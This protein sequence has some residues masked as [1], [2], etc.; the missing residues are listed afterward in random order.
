MLNVKIIS[1]VALNSST[2]TLIDL[3]TLAVETIMIQCRDAIDVL[4][5][6]SDSPS[7][8]YW[9]MKSGT[10]VFVG[11]KGRQVTAGQFVLYAK[12][13]SSTPSLEIFIVQ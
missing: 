1:A 13:A 6:N 2:Y 5:A 8:A 4:L 7:A 12:A 3:S 9:T 10:S 11:I